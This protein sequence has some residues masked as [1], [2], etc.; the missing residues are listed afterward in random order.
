LQSF[1]NANITIT[2]I[3]FTAELTGA[4]SQGYA[5]LDTDSTSILVSGVGTFQLMMPATISVSTIPS[6]VAPGTTVSEFLYFIESGV[7]LVGAS[8]ST[9]TPWSML[10]P[11]GPISSLDGMLS[12]WNWAPVLTADGYT[13]NLYGA[14]IQLTFQALLGP[15]V[16]CA[17]SPS[18]NVADVQSVINEALGV[19]PADADTNGDGVVNVVD[20]QAVASAVLGCG[21]NGLKGALVH[22][23][24]LA[25]RPWRAHK[26]SI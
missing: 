7:P 13:V 26:A 15:G 9:T 20:V 4:V 23:R 5:S 10:G 18:G 25:A 17:S 1:T 3:G 6:D 11:V 14:S 19:A 24:I 2:T 12:E 8:T 16:P 21:V 22:S